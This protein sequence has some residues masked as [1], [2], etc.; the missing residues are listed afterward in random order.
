MKIS[1][2]EPPRRFQVGLDIQITMKDCGLIK[3]NSNEQIT[4]IT[5]DGKEYDL[6]RKDW[7]YYATPSINSRLINNGLRS[8]LVINKSNQLFVM[9]VEK[10]KQE[11]FLD[12]I[13]TSRQT[14]LCWLD[15]KDS[16]QRIKDLFLTT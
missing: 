1:L 5:K 11:I 7:G 9:L 16:L 4:F 15:E 14:L 2:K 6:A 3:L 12:Y 8:A 10:N 13:N